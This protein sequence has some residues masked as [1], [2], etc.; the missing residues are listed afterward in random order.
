M[1]KSSKE[2]LTLDLQNK[3]KAINKNI[4]VEMTS[5]QLWKHVFDKWRFFGNTRTSHIKFFIMLETYYNISKK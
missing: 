1:E 2:K 4:D 5:E 3:K